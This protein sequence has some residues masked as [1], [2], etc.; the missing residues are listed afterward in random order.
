MQCICVLWVVE[1]VACPAAQEMDAGV[2]CLIKRKPAAL[3]F[4]N[5]K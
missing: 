4:Y 1:G 3:V 5:V 2:L